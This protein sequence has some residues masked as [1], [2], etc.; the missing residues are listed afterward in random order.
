[1]QIE[2]NKN[3]YGTQIKILTQIAESEFKLFKS[4][5]GEPFVRLKVSEYSECISID[6]AESRCVIND[7]FF[8]KTNTLPDTKNVEKLIQHL[9]YKASKANKENVFYRLAGLENKFFIDLG[10]NDFKYVEID[11]SGWSIKANSHINFY[12]TKSMKSLP[13]P[14]RNGNIQDLKQFLN[15]DSENDFKL[16]VSYIIGSLSYGKE[17]PILI[18]Q[19]PQGSAKSTTSEVI[20]SLIDP[21]LPSLRSFPRNEE[22]IFIAG[23][24]SHLI[25]YDNL[26]GINPKMSDSLCRISTGCG[27]GGRKLY[28]NDQESVIE[29]SRPIIINGIDDLTDRADLVDR[30]LVLFLPKISD[31]QRKLSTGLWADFENLKPL[32][33]GAILDGLSSSLANK[34][35]INL[36]FKP[37]M[38]DFCINSCAGMLAFNYTVD[39]IS[40]AFM[41]NKYD[42]AIDTVEASA[43]GRAIR[44]LMQKQLVW[45]GT[46]TSLRSALK[47]NL[48]CDEQ[49]GFTR[50]SS[51]F[52]RDLNRIIPSL[53]PEG[54][55]VEKNRTSS[56]RGI[57][58]SKKISSLP[59]QMS[60]SNQKLF[61]N[62]D[63]DDILQKAELNN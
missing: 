49:Y 53:K 37:R 52:S 18:L 60:S 42:I 61:F 7:L 36:P 34:S 56:K 40:S 41:Q 1:M 22:D 21:S 54:I 27:S 50:S 44:K 33:F 62:D 17:Y 20:K 24:N 3:E 11:E 29:I 58:I 39:D 26:S 48:E 15:L 12:R 35:K 32:L 2:N 51:V 46:I 8:R 9:S 38:A 59:L 23:R 16:I 19:G 57:T 43:I 4:Q 30:A 31:N 13:V 28:T 10:S 47:E 6:S 5:D 14:M 55:E 45:I 25:C 63:Y